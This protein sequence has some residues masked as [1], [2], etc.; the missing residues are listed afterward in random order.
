MT[1]K[2]NNAQAVLILASM[3]LEFWPAVSLQSCKL[4]TEK[5]DISV[6]LHNADVP[7]GHT[8]PNPS[9]VLSLLWCLEMAE[10]T[11]RDHLWICPSCFFLSSLIYFSWRCGEKKL[12]SVQM[13]TSQL[14][15]LNKLLIYVFVYRIVFVFKKISVKGGFASFWPFYAHI[16]HKVSWN[17][18]SIMHISN[19]P[20]RAVSTIVHYSLHF[21]QPLHWI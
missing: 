4:C 8:F 3:G 18:W 9:M 20:C 5:G 12:V 7:S 2:L 11:V 16:K 21:P 10:A 13:V 1:H 17:G 14:L 15:I 6:T 19:H